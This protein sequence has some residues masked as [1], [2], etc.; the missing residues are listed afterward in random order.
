MSG[1]VYTLMLPN[2]YESTAIAQIKFPD[3]N[4]EKYTTD[5]LIALT[6]Q[7]AVLA[8][9]SEIFYPVITELNLQESWGR[10]GEK[11]PRNIVYKILQN[12]VEITA[13]KNTVGLIRFSVKRDSPTEPSEIANAICEV[14][15]NQNDGV[16]VAKVAK[17]NMRPV[18]PNLFR[19]VLFSLIQAGILVGIGLVILVWGIRKESP[20]KSSTVR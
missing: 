8:D 4:N 17:P 15:A 9:N 2:I 13:D 10:M 5:A 14:Y 20:T 3:S 16:T 19:S 1:V 11:L 18:S 7:K 12:S 6:K